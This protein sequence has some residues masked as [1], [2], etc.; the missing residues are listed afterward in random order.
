[1]LLSNQARRPFIGASGNAMD[2]IILPDHH[3]CST[4]Y[5]LLS[6]IQAPAS[7]SG[8]ALLSSSLRFGLPSVLSSLPEMPSSASCLHVHH[9][10]MVCHAQK[11]KKKNKKHCY[12]L[13][14]VSFLQPSPLQN[15]HIHTFYSY[16]NTPSTIPRIS[17]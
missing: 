8:S 5:T 17:S 3:H 14:M 2:G 11:K 7:S 15:P 10:T 4:I 16:L 12:Q 13:T 1:M 6:V 9:S